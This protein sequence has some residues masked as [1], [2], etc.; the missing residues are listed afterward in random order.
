M[1]ESIALYPFEAQDNKDH[2]R[3]IT[4]AGMKE[5]LEH[6]LFEPFNKNKILSSFKTYYAFANM[7]FNEEESLRA[8][9]VAG[10]NLYYHNRSHAVEQTTFDAINLTR[11]ILDRND[12]FS[13]HL[14]AEGALSIVL[15]AMFHDT[16]YVS[17]GPVDN[18]AARTPVHVDESIKTFE[19]IVN[20]LGLPEGLDAKKLKLLGSIGIHGTHF[21][22][23][24]SR[25]EESKKIMN[26]LTIEE[27]KEAQIV[28]LT[29]QLAD[30]GG[31]CARKDYFPTLVKALREELNSA[32]PESGNRIVGE[33][34]E[35]FANCE[36]FLNTFVRRP[37]KP[38]KGTSIR[39][40][41]T[42]A[43]A[44]LKDK[45]SIQ[46]QKAWKLEFLPQNE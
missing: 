25:L 17:D 30:L 8:K 18:Y 43:Q 34:H 33:D 42:T 46:F 21:P 1:K 14:T 32:L 28:R 31:Q 13:T 29:T 36:F 11:A 24:A 27:K 44:F 35:L 20:L 4:D 41:E 7:Y 37:Q 39:N 5:L 40:V 15:G 2:I 16:G 10:A 3:E 22:F 45:D 23:T 12:T 19:S 38:I 26:K 9:N 6:D